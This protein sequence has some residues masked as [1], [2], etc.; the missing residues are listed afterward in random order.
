MHRNE[1]PIYVF[2]FWELRGLSP[3][4]HVHVS[5]SDLFPGLVHIF[6]CCRVGKSIVGLYKSLT[7]THGCGNWDCG[8]TIPFLGIFVSNFRYCF[9]AACM[10]EQGREELL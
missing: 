3:T 8:R 9:F 6:S 10:R 1:N 2:I 5:V 4:F 7:H